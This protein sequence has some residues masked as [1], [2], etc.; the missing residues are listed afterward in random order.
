MKRRV[1]V[2]QSIRLSAWI[3]AV[4][5]LG[6][7]IPLYNYMDEQSGSEAGPPFELLLP[8]LTPLTCPELP[9]PTVHTYAAGGDVNHYILSVYID[10]V[11]AATLYAAYG[12]SEQQMTAQNSSLIGVFA[13]QGSE[14]N[15]YIPVNGPQPEP[16]H[17]AVAARSGSCEG[18]WAQVK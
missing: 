18:E 12:S 1:T 8:A 3:L 6:S 15:R 2:F 4:V 5:C 16:A 10:P 7:C 17:L 13:L 14:Q 9:P 11:P